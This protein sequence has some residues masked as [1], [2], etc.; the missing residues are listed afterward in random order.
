MIP[1]VMS[2]KALD[3]VLHVS[4]FQWRQRFVL[5][6]WPTPSHSHALLCWT[7]FNQHSHDSCH[8]LTS[9]NLTKTF[10]VRRTAARDVSC[11]SPFPAWGSR[12]TSGCTLSSVRFALIRKVV[13][14]ILCYR[15]PVVV[16]L[17]RARRFTFANAHRFDEN[18][19]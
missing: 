19:L 8:L 9:R 12:P 10:M 5:L 4:I 13:L 2:F 6:V 18:A 1:M 16:K 15:F 17:P 7:P 14:S 3:G 11:S